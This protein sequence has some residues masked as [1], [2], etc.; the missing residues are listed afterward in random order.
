MFE[1]LIRRHLPATVKQLYEFA[2]KEQ[3]QDWGGSPCHHRD[4][5]RVNDLEC[6]HQLRRELQQ[7]AVHSG[8]KGGLWHCK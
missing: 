2:E 6:M 8:G 1:E 3:P 5:I 7:I 4:R